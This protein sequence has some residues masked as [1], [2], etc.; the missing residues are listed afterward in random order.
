MEAIASLQLDWDA[1]Q[2][3]NSGWL[4]P[5]L[6]NASARLQPLKKHG[7]V[8]CQPFSLRDWHSSS[9][10]RSDAVATTI[11][12]DCTISP[13]HNCQAHFVHA[14]CISKLLW[15]S[16]GRSCL[17]RNTAKWLPHWQATDSAMYTFYR[18]WGKK[19]RRGAMQ[20]IRQQW[21]LS[22]NCSISGFCCRLLLEFLIIRKL[23][24]RLI[25]IEYALMG[26][27]IAQDWN[28]LILCHCCPPL[29]WDYPWVLHHSPVRSGRLAKQVSRH[30][31]NHWHQLS[32]IEWHARI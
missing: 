25:R 2:H 8:L 20:L 22:H 31:Y 6:Y 29:I 3:W 13:F 17:H 4:A 10:W 19:G 12:Y 30:P 24:L 21:M 14:R 7:A 27:Q 11:V 9:P 5:V 1:I 16:L 32:S 23:H 18:A 26:S 15:W 28:Y